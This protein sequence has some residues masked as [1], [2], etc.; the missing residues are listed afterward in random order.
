MSVLL[1]NY[2]INTQ[3]QP[4]N[5]SITISI[6]TLTLQNAGSSSVKATDLGAQ[7]TYM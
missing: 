4:S 7:F 6:Q 1:T 2:V 5:I 3:K